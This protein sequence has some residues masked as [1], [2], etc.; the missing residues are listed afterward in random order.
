MPVMW[1]EVSMRGAL[2][3]LLLDAQGCTNLLDSLKQLVE[4][5]ILNGNNQY[6][7]EVS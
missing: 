2:L 3:D 7:T 6:R 5:E 4:V 1:V